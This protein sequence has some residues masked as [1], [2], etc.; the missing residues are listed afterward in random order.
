ML[1]DAARHEPC[2][3]LPWDEAR[4]RAA[5]ERIVAETEA[6]FVPGR[7]WPLH[8]RDAGGGDPS[9]TTPVPPLYFGTAGVMWALHHLQ[10]VGAARLARSYAPHLDDLV[11]QDAS[12]LAANGD[13]ATASY[14]MGET[15]IA[16]L[17]FGLEPTAARSDRLEALIA[18]H[19]DD[20]TRELM[21][22]SPGTMLAA[23]FLHDRTG[24]ARWRELFA[25]SAAALGARL[26]WSD[27]H[28]CLYW[29]QELYGQHSTYLD[30]VHGFVAT[31]AVLVGGRHLLEPAAWDGWQACIETT[32]RRTVTRDG[33]LA[34]WRPFLDVE[35]DG[36]G[37][38]LVQFCHGAPGF[39][40]CL[41]DLPGN[42]LDDLLLAAGETTWRAGPLRK[43]S[44]LCHGTGG[45][46]YA[47]L[48]LHRRFGD[49][50]WL[51]RAR[52]F[53]MRGI[54]Q[55]EAERRAVGHM[56]FSLWTGDLGFAVYLWHCIQGAGGFPTLDEFFAAPVAGA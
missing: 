40:V 22:G 41:A 42:A 45:N 11:A 55:T 3:V 46:G 56:R 25:R 2:R 21:W 15:A 14:L 20:P 49:A 28:G 31:A 51:G 50:R 35:R 52:A 30:A 38:L 39:V 13:T 47:F 9:D 54:E 4:A 6:A 32:V 8:P 12:W 33:D 10:A 26:E 34:N 18:G 43:G 36:E 19:V 37:P 23:R 16:L 7:G 29:T 53:A 27:A 5:I 48:A 44:N 1:F 24:E 17:A